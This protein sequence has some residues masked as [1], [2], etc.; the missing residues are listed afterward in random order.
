MF[1]YFVI[2][3]CHEMLKTDNFPTLNALHDTCANIYLQWNDK[4]SN[5]SPNNFGVKQVKYF[6]VPRNCLDLSKDNILKEDSL[7]TCS[8]IHVIAN[9]KIDP[10]YWWMKDNSVFS[11]FLYMY[12]LVCFLDIPNETG[13][14]YQRNLCIIYLLLGNWKKKVMGIFVYFTIMTDIFYWLF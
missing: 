10:M 1:W 11:Q 5:I 4:L 6:I 2:N 7:H 8:M 12:I 3:T 9:Y 13:K 14:W